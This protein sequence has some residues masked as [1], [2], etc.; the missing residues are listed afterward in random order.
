MTPP[1][2]SRCLA[3]NA[4][5]DREPSVCVNCDSD[6]YLISYIYEEKNRDR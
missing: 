3:C 1:F 5:Y 4:T 2:W 6:E